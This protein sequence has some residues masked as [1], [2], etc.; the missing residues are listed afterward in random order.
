MNILNSSARSYSRMIDSMLA[1]LS[2]SGVSLTLMN[3]LIVLLTMLVAGFVRGFV[4]FGSALIIIMI[5]SAIFGLLFAV[6]F[7][8]LTGIPSAVQLL[9]T[10]YRHSEKAFV[11]PFGVSAVIVDQEPGYWLT[12]LPA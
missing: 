8:T 7:A 3:F 11:L 9:P 4:G 12:L 6:P 5:L 10:A 2:L 1:L